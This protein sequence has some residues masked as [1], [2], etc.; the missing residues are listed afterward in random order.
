MDVYENEQSYFFS[1]CSDQ[2]ITDDVLT[3]LLTFPNVV[4]TAHQAFL[5][6]EALETIASSTSQNL[7]DAQNGVQ[8]SNECRAPA[9]QTA[10]TPTTRQAK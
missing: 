9:E 4:I 6:K 10:S 2:V 7:K 1:D 3:T 5:T 8:T